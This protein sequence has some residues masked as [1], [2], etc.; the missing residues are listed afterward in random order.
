MATTH[1]PLIIQ[2]ENLLNDPPEMQ[3]LNLPIQQGVMLPVRHPTFTMLSIY[4]CFVLHET[5]SDE[6]KPIK[7]D[8]RGIPHSITNLMHFG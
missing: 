1:A 6:K 7:C 8:L 4:V 2:V 5:R 3:A